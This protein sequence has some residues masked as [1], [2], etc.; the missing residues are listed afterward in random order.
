MQEELSMLT[1]AAQRRAAAFRTGPGTYSILFIIAFRTYIFVLLSEQFDL[2][3]GC[4]ACSNTPDM[5]I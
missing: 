3:I 2:Y 4:V 5:L 1:A